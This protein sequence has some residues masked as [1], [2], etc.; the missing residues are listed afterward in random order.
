ML[1]Q[2]SA[3]VMHAKLN[4]HTLAML[5]IAPVLAWREGSS[6]ITLVCAIGVGE[7]ASQVGGKRE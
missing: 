2:V 7:S 3:Q 5:G 4:N 6:M 1:P